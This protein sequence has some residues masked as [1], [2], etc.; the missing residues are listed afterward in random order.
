LL[1]LR[2]DGVGDGRRAPTLRR[3]DQHSLLFS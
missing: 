2:A 1:L 3:R